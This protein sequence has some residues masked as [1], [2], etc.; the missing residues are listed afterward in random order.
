[1]NMKKNEICFLIGAARSGTTLL[2]EQILSFHPEITY[3]GEPDYIW[4]HAI[5]HRSDDVL[6]KQDFSPSDGDK[7]KRKLV[8]NTTIDK[9][10]ILEKSPSN[11]F[12][13]SYINQ[14]LPP[15]LSLFI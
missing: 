4:Q 14:L 15:M 5:K 2:G 1:M 13:I 11:C 8:A 12:R 3:L 9:N 10:V 6:Q 7:I